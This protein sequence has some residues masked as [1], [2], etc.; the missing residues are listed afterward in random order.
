MLDAFLQLDYAGV[1]AFDV[2][3]HEGDARAYRG[4]PPEVRE[5]GRIA[6]N[7]MAHPLMLIAGERVV[8]NDFALGEPRRCM[9]ISGANTGGKTV[10]LMGVGLSALLVRCGM[11]V[12][13]LAGSRFDLFRDVRADIGDRQSLGQSLSTFS[14]QIRFLVETLAGA[15]PRSL[16]LIDEMLTGT[17]PEEGAALASTALETLA[18]SGACC[19]VTT[20]YG[21]LKVLAAAHESIVNAS[22]S[23]DP[24]RLRPTFRLITGLPGASFAGQYDSFLNV[25]G[26]DALVERMVAVWASLYSP[27]AIAYRDRLGVAHAGAKM[28]VLVQQQLDPDAAGVLFTRDPMSSDGSRMLVNATFGLGEGVVAGELPTDVAD[29]VLADVEQLMEHE[30]NRTLAYGDREIYRIDADGSNITQLTFTPTM[31]VSRPGTPEGS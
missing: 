9:V 29:D 31:M 17:A 12:P 19:V 27:H 11:P 4:V 6:L 30:Q 2:S 20:H 3:G 5:E 18:A 10:L 28:A 1:E 13:A 14:A 26:L 22:V 24:E 25:S 23:F 7:G 21:E 8:R 16:V 15:G